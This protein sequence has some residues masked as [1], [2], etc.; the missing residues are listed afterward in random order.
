MQKCLQVTDEAQAIELQ[1][2][3]PLLVE[4][5]GDNIKIT[6]PGDL[7]LAGFYLQQQRAGQ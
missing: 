4:G 2:Y 3:R 5:S 6:S 1:G 7:Q